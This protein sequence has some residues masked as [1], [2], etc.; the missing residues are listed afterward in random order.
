MSSFTDITGQRFGKL[1]A[2][3][4]IGNSK[5]ECICDCGNTTTVLYGNLKKRGTKSCGCM[6]KSFNDITGLKSGML[7]AIKYI[8]K[9]KWECLCDCGNSTI[10]T[11]TDL[12]MGTAKSCGCIKSIDITGR[13]FGMLTVVEYV[14]HGKWK[15]LCDCG[16]VKI[17]QYKHLKYGNTKSCG[18]LLRK[19]AL[20]NSKLAAHNRIRNFYETKY[21][22]TPINYRIT[23]LDGDANNLSDNNLQ[24]VDIHVYNI[25]VNNKLL[26]L[27]DITKCAIEAYTLSRKIKEMGL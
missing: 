19:T 10:A 14:G 12:I 26:G 3:K 17:A 2:T 18:C 21:G 16:S 20:D 9:S 25:L 11:S 5:W 27:G 4:Y 1:V 23:A 6:K 13:R 8:G 7:T 15:C 22:N 24:M